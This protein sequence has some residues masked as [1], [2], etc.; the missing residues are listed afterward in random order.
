[1]SVRLRSVFSAQARRTNPG[2]PEPST[3]DFKTLGVK[4]LGFRV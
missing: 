2:V 1:M 4:G 3:L